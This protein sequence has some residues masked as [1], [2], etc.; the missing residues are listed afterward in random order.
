MSRQTR[1]PHQNITFSNKRSKEG[2]SNPDRVR[3]FVGIRE[4]PASM[5]DKQGDQKLNP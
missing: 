4:V 1:Y 3:E 2:E 5:E